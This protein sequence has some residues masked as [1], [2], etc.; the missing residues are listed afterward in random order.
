MEVSLISARHLIRDEKVRVPS[1]L[2]ERGRFIGQVIGQASITVIG[3]NHSEH[4][5]RERMT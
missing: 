4:E 1:S 3:C 2:R 5:D